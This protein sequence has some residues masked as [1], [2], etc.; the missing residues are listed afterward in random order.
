MSRV[1]TLV[2]VALVAAACGAARP[3]DRTAGGRVP[4]ER[5]TARL[6]A[7]A[8]RDIVHLLSRATFGPRSIDIARVREMGAAA[9]LESQLAPQ[10]G[11]DV[12]TPAALAGLATLT[13]TTP[14][15]LQEFPRPDAATLATVRSGAM[16]R[17]EAMATYPPERRP[18]WILHELQAARAVRAVLAER[19]LEEVMVDFWFNHFNV[20]ARKADVR[21]YVTSYERDAI[22]PHALGRFQDL[23]RATARHPAMLQYLDNWV[24]TRADLAMPFRRSTGLNENYARE[25]LELH[26]L[27]VD[28]GYTQKD[29]TEVARAFT[30]WSIAQPQKLGRFVFRWFLHD[31]GEKVV[32]GEPIPA[33]GGESDGERVID[34]LVRHPA[35]ARFIATKIVRRF[36]ADDPPAALVERVAAT[37]RDTDGHIP[38]ML[39]TVFAA[40]EFWA[41]AARR[42]KVKKPLEFVA[43]AVRA[44]GARVDGRGGAAL[45]LAVAEIGE[46]LYEMQPPTGHPDRAEA[47]LSSGAVLA[48]MNFALA[49]AHNRVPGVRVEL[50]A[51]VGGVDPARPDA[52]LDRLL[53][54]LLHEDATAA[55]RAVLAA[56]VADR[57]VT[58]F[59]HH[60]RG[61]ASRDMERLAAL[62]IASPEFQRR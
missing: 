44:V 53:A 46:P 23:V 37:Y 39:R 20:F 57:S 47:W 28:G 8:H 25:L 62:V 9:W 52:V 50:P 14:E 29:V 43:S 13:K 32:L 19:Q 34:I 16:T 12:T 5:E 21:W 31:P 11:S 58:R 51:L 30:G 56:Q 1:I 3:A 15:L 36:V 26:T 42:A 61:P 24:S 59:D 2:L 10:H 27:G 18:N 40:P 48:R 45:A 6:R 22:R 38:A 49:L 60:E 55:T 17:A 41:P 35:T 7:L 4:N 33:G 54:V